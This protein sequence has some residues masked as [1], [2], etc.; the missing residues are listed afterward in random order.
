MLTLI[1]IVTCFLVLTALAHSSEEKLQPGW[2]EAAAATSLTVGYAS[3]GL[4]SLGMAA[5]G[6][7]KQS[8]LP[9]VFAV[10]IIFLNRVKS[11]REIAQLLVAAKSKVLSL[12]AKR[13]GPV[14]IILVLLVALAV[15]ISVGPANHP[16]SAD[17]HVGYPYLYWLTGKIGIDG[18]LHQGLT[19]LGDLAYIQFFN[20]NTSWSIRTVQSLCI[21]ILASTLARK[22]TNKLLTIA[23]LSSPILLQWLTIGKPL[24]LGEIC[25]AISY[26]Y[27]KE[28]KCGTSSSML[29]ACILAAVSFKISAL[30]IAA[31]ICVDILID[32]RKQ[33][34]ATVVFDFPLL[35]ISGACIV[36]A[37]LYR[38]LVTGNPLYPLM[39]QVFTPENAQFIGFESFLR[40]Y[41]RDGFFPASLIIPTSPGAIGIT[42]GPALGLALAGLITQQIRSR[43]FQDTQW[44]GMLQTLMLLV[45]GQGRPDY[46]ACPIVL[47]LCGRTLIR[48][49]NPS[50]KSSPGNTLKPKLFSIALA[51][52]IAILASQVLLWFFLA[53]SSLYQSL[54]AFHKFKCSAPIRRFNA[55]KYQALLSHSICER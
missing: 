19:G 35:Q 22:G 41:G 23:L 48:D 2:L 3:Q 28:R 13:L 46:Y 21:P 5:N 54:A 1:I 26:I 44:T 32:W 24:F 29:I 34:K 55:Q 47:L 38:Y 6:L 30:I 45:F 43:Q 33:R 39:P 11:R 50:A 9:A 16:D 49:F 17:Y 27:W 51:G 8:V 4:L 37:L 52:F 36:A 7:A 40:S 31:P 25:I 18:G 42:V 20:E 15:L 14:N 53:F 10:G 12:S